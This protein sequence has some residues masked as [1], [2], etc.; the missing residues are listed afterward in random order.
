M[1][2]YGWERK[3]SFIAS[4]LESLNFTAYLRNVG[5]ESRFGVQGHAA[6]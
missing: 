1:T 4:G 3:D 6:L 5:R 2:H